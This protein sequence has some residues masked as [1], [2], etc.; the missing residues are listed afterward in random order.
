[1][2]VPFSGLHVGRHRENPPEKL[3]VN[4]QVMLGTQPVLHHQALQEV[5]I[6]LCSVPLGLVWG[7]VQKTVFIYDYSRTYIFI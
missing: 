6:M 7:A 4:H 2:H 3:K 1:V 5:C